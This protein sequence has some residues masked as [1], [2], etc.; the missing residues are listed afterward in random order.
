MKK[1]FFLFSLIICAFLFGQESVTKNYLA[2]D[3]LVSAKTHAKS[4]TDGVLAQKYTIRNIGDPE[5]DNY[6]VE[7]KVN[8]ES[9]YVLAIVN[10]DF[11]RRDFTMQLK[12]VQYHD[13]KTGGFSSISYQNKEEGILDYYDRTKKVL[14]TLHADYIAPDLDKK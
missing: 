5:S 12:S 7:Y 6:D 10:F 1:Y 4:Y 8:G 3:N 9:G 11:R 14:L 13:N 2:Q